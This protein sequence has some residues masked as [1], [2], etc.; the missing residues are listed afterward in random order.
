MA[1]QSPNAF[2][3]TNE[4]AYWYSEELGLYFDNPNLVGIG[5]TYD[6]IEEIA[7]ETQKGN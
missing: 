3:L 1:K 2:D 7:W 4:I 6:E 5:L